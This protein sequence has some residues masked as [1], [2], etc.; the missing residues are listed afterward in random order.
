MILY[1]LN[2]FA[3]TKCIVK[4]IKRICSII[5]SKSILKGTYDESRN[6]KCRLQDFYVYKHN[7]GIKFKKKKKKMIIQLDIFYES[8]K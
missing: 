2:Y 6:H 7:K 4:S 3:K 1:K 5:M 8:N